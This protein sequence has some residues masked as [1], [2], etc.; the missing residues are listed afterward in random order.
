MA[1]TRGADIAYLTIRPAPAAA[2]GG[3]LYEVGVIGHGPSRQDLV[4]H[5]TDEIRTWDSGYRF[6]TV[7]FEIPDAPA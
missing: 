4:E 1:T 2:D 3:K 6:R 7:R 5:V